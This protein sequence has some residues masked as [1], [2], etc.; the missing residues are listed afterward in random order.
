M[1]EG[2]PRRTLARRLRAR[3]V[4]A[5][6]WLACRLPERPLLALADLVGQLWYR[7]APDRRRRAR[8][9]L[10]R[11]AR[12]LAEHDL[13][14]PA[15]RAA[16]RDPR[17]LSRLV[18]DAFRHSV[19]YYIQLARA[20]MVD[21]AYLARRL[22]FEDEAAVNAA[23]D[24]PGGKL[25]VGLHIGWF[26]L[27]ALISVARTGRPALVP[28]ETVSDPD[29]QAYIVG[30]RRRLGLELIELRAAKRLL[31]GA[32]ER[33]ETVGILG[34]RDITGG[35]I[36]TELFGAPAPLAAGPA[37]L[38]LQTG[39]TPY[40]FGV[41]RDAGDVYH[42]DL[43]PVPLPADGTR[44]ERVTAYLDAEARAFEH[45]VAQ[46]PEQWL[47]VFHPIWPDLERAPSSRPGVAPATAGA[48][49]P[50]ERLAREA[51]R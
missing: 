38:A 14:P 7:L 22:V 41:W 32:L 36:D 29:L 15:A 3:A 34:D 44:R 5:A 12:W 10:A 4:V 48:D 30:T 17:A 19:R 26:E 1:T 23:L 28:S 25:F 39:V 37:L 50:G 31:T 51:A 42:A 20:P 49:E 6:S 18:R 43:R 45:F 40:V 47:A 13:G 2:R 8:R 24:A 11:V 27:P 46:A 35:G 9:N 33:G 21:K 16:A